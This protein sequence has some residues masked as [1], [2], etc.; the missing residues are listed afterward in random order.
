MAE[1]LLPP[2]AISCQELK[3]TALVISHAIPNPWED[4]TEWDI[5]QFA[6][7]M[8]NV[9]D[10]TKYFPHPQWGHISDPATVLDVHGKVLVW[11]LPGIIPP[12]RVEHVDEIHIPLKDSL[13]Q[14]SKTGC[15]SKRRFGHKHVPE[16]DGNEKFG[17]GRLMNSP[18]TF[19]QA[20][21]DYFW[22]LIDPQ[23]LE[24]QVYESASLKKPAV[25]QWLRDI[26][27]AEDFWNTI[28]EIV[29]PDL[30]QVGKEAISAKQHWVT[31][32]PPCPVRW[33]SIYLGI[34]VIVNQETPPHQDKASAP[35]LLD[36]V[37][38]TMVFLAGKLLTH[39]VPKWEKGERI[40]LAHYMKDAIHN[41]F[42]L[43]RPMFTWQKDLL[44]PSILANPTKTRRGKLT[45]KEVD[46]RHLY[47][48]SGSLPSTPQ[49]PRT[50]TSSQN[51][52]FSNFPNSLDM[53]NSDWNDA[54]DPPQSRRHTKSQ[55]DFVREWLPWRAEYLNV[56]L[57]GEQLAKGGICEQC[58]EAEGSVW[59]MSCT[60]VH[61]WCGP[62]AV[63]AHRNL[64]FHKVQRWNGT[65][66]EPTSLM[67]LG[68]LWHIGHGGDPCP[69]NSSDPDPDE[70]GYM[71]GE[72]PPN[73]RH[74]DDLAIRRS[75][76]FQMI[77][78]HT[79]GI[80][81]CPGSHP[82]DWHLDL[83]RQRLFPASISKP[84]TVFAFAVLDHFLIDA[85]ECKTSAMSFYQKLKR[86]TNNAFPERDR[87]RELMRVSRLWRDL[88]HRKWFGFGHD[89]EQDP[90]DGGL[91]LFCPACPQPGVN[92][93]ADWKVHYDRDT[94]MRQYVI[95]GNFT[96][97]HMKMN[98]P[99]LDVAL[100]DGKGYMVAEVP[101]QSHLKQSLDSKERSTCSNHRAINATNINK[102]NLQSTGISATACA[103]HGCF[104]PHSVVDFQKG[105][106]YMNTDYSICNALGYHSESITKALVIYDVGCQWSINFRTRVKNSPSLLLPPALE[107]VPAVGKFH[108]AAHK[109]SCF[110]RYSLNF[111]K[112]VGHLDREILE[113]LW[114]PF[115]KISPTARSMTQAHR[116]EV[117]DDH[118]R[119]S[120]WK[121]L[122]GCKFMP[123]ITVPS[124]LKKYKN[125]NKC[126]EEMNQAYEQLTAVLD[127]DKVARWESDALR[128]E[129]DRGE[130]LDI[131][132]LKGEKAPTFQEVWLQLMKNPK[133]PSGNVGLVAWLAEGISIEDSYP[134]STRQEVKISEKRQR[135]SSRIEKFHSDAQA[136]CKGLDIDGT[137]T[138]QDDPAFC[139]SDEEEDEDREFWDDD[140]GDWEAPEEEVEGL[141]SELMS[142]W[143]PSAI[144]AAKLTEL[145]LHDLLKEERELRIGQANNCLD[146][147]RTDLGNKAMLEGT[148]T[149]KEI[150][151]VV[152][153]VN[154]HVRSYQR[155]RQAI[156]R[157]DPDGNMAEK[158]QEILPEDLV[159]SKEVTEE[160]RFG[161]GTSK[162]AWFWVID[163]EKSQLN[164]EAGGL[165]EEFYRINQLKARA[166]RD[167]WKEEV[168][169]VRHEMLWT[170]LWFEYHKKMWEQRA[171]QST[172]P[173]KEAYAN[174]QMGLWSDF[175]SK[176]RLMFH[177]KQMDGI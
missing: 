100:S 57:E 11:Y 83:L 156:L 40:A 130:A 98:K 123:N 169:L 107:I 69:Q 102:S 137:F 136:F 65:H 24:D 146:Q 112:G 9:I 120:N 168:S 48:P 109:L 66:Y 29:L 74:S 10:K 116:Q 142:I 8:R 31:T 17:H 132:L 30:A 161:Q 78:V 36:L 170:G 1:E 91:A 87:Y 96:A 61:A 50:M 173:G 97:Q 153:R 52:N 177:G 172:E 110:P 140:E 34:D 41:R 72:E 175:A 59:C 133:S 92:L 115:N 101:Y 39:S 124:L 144:G 20:H 19:Q 14:C 164:V 94:I 126:L 81:Y 51:L 38:G 33:P 134:M 64:P 88:K 18:A 121:K 37:P 117:Y 80:F 138:P 35:S 27:Y 12:A 167:K 15:P 60:G 135:L 16:E 32:Q 84:K 79:E 157:L 125:S 62:C 154:K 150:Q 56:I 176:A 145:G 111:I 58:E 114:A 163:G 68:F 152:A 147:L 70:S 165:M 22:R 71:T 149:K 148:S 174:K 129:A 3:L 158:Y 95:D 119:D 86:F 85:L 13:V 122:R 67:E 93:P 151:K 106:R 127:P 82:N 4:V 23:R 6:E 7:P 2:A 49:T 108:L 159:V 76:Q 45:H 63:K 105:E 113:T 54:D 166:R 139:G 103:W 104:V 77:I 118:M 155:T 46:A 47:L 21:M 160:N 5:D 90:G 25:R 44:G 171:L 53:P 128:A 141:A 75:S 28:A 131:Y 55:N 99:E 89:M 43:A 73:H 26:T 162:L 42:G 143:M